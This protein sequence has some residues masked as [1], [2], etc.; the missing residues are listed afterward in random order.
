MYLPEAEGHSMRYGS[1]DVT[2]NQI[3]DKGDYV[4]TVLSIAE[5]KVN[6]YDRTLHVLRPVSTF[7]NLEPRHS[8]PLL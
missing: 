5:T 3:T 8:R 1:I 6:K 7:I 2:V 4:M